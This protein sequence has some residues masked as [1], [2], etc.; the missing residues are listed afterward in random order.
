MHYLN[1][2]RLGY[3]QASEGASV[4]FPLFPALVQLTASLT[5]GDIII[6]G[7][8][9]ST[10]SCMLALALLY[11]LKQSYFGPAAAKWSVVAL[12]AYP[13][14]LF[15]IAPYSESLFLAL[16]LAAFLAARERRWWLAGGLG[17]LAGLARQNGM[18]ISAA[19][20][21]LAW[22]EWREVRPSLFDRRFVSFLIGISLPLAGG[23]A[24][25]AWRSANGFPPNLAD[26]GAILRPCDG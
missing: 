20:L 5:G 17:F 23:L 7:L 19:L 25:L 10:L 24:F 2:A 18:I 3:F 13:T 15:L 12:A 1:L 8:V 4:F 26:P 11:I 22:Q 9:V 14:A 16:T 6:A 21:L